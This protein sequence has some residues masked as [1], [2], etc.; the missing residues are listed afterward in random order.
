M[1]SLY[2]S[3][4]PL[5]LRRRVDCMATRISSH[6]GVRLQG[7]LAEL[8]MTSSRVFLHKVLSVTGVPKDSS[9]LA[10]NS[11]TTSG[12]IVS[13]SSSWLCL[14]FL[15]FG[16]VPGTTWWPIV[17]RVLAVVWMNPGSSTVLESM[18]MA[19][20]GNCRTRRPVVEN[21]DALSGQSSKTS[22]TT[23]PSA[24]RMIIAAFCSVISSGSTVI[25]SVIK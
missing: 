13:R 3:S 25:D 11:V 7:S 14:A 4:E 24:F 10:K 17:A 12:L 6:T 8:H 21:T 23:R 9:T 22:K 1:N 16:R 5:F 15:T 2:F 18:A 20:D 19:V